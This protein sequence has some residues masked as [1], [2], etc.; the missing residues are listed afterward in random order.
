MG[1]LLRTRLWL[2][3]RDIGRFTR[4]FFAFTGNVVRLRTVWLYVINGL[5]QNSLIAETRNYQA[6]AS[7]V[8]G[9]VNLHIQA[10]MSLDVG[11]LLLRRAAFRHRYSPPR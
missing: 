6:F 7:P 1:S 9:T 4:N 8:Q 2:N 11:L 5:P 3:F 10:D